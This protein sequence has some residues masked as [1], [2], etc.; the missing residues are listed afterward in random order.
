M[1]TTPARAVVDL[2][3]IRHNVAALAD[4]A[5]TA[6]VMAV[7]KADAYGHGLVP[8][9]R[10]ALQGGA[11]WLGVAQLEEAMALRAAGIDAPVL[12]W[13]FAPG[14]QLDAALTARVDLSVSAPWALADVVAAAGRTGVTARIHLKVDTGLSRAGVTP[15][16]YPELLDAALAAEAD[17]LLKLVGLWS[18][19]AWADAPQHPTVLAQVGVLREAVA[20]AEARGARLEVRHIANSAATL[21]T[22]DAHLDLVRPGI[23]VYGITPDPAL[24]SAAELGL[25]PAMSVDAALTLV[26]SVPAGSGV[27]Y[28]HTYTTPTDTVLGLV[29]LGY[30]DGIPRHASGTGPLLVGGRRVTVA[31]RV[32]MDQFVVDLGPGASEA[33]GDRAVLF[34][35]GDDGEPTVQDWA[36]AAGTIGYEIVTRFGPRVPRVYLGELP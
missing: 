26:K 19:F 22:P 29:P 12:A 31:G 23:A 2:S 34:G 36:A 24:G 33:A 17:G 27:S 1:S 10:A 3:A 25:R 35:P 14:A 4:R 28:G 6:Q 9:A 11:T 13:I 7:V 8:V 5:A 30:A 21:T 20:L 15:A 18:H 32:C 16:D